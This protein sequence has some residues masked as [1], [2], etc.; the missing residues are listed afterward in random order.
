MKLDVQKRI[1]SD[2]L[3][4]SKK[5]IVFDE[6]RLDEIKEAITKSDLKSLVKDKAISVLPKRGISRVRARK[7]MKQKKKG[8][9]KGHGS[10]KGKNTARLPGKR[11]WINKIRALKTMLKVLRDKKI[12]ETSTYQNLYN[13]ARGGFFRSRR[14]LR[15]YI[16]E[17]GLIKKKIIK[18]KE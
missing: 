7:I 5:R 16:N 10:R 8:R 12:V 13:K 1:I 14:H 2:L 3:E 18:K 11:V 9:M 15:L 4:V 17:Q 6:T